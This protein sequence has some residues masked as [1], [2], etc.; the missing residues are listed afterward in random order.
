MPPSLSDCSELILATTNPH[1]VRELATLLLPL[2]ILVRSLDDAEE[3]SPVNEDGTTIAENARKKAIGY[4]RQLGQ[5]VLADDTGLEV[6][7][8][9]GA[10]GVRSARYAGDDATQA[11][12]LAL[13]VEHLKQVPDENRTARFVCHL[14]LADP[15]GKVVLETNGECRGT[16]R[17]E[18]IG[19]YGFGYDSLFEVAGVGKTLAEL[20]PEATA[21]VGHRGKAAREL[22]YAWNSV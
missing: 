10:P 4:A 14:C 21:Q 15:T 8:L 5:W 2:K 7:A 1:K 3:V 13:L 9:N 20:N 17:R 11:M 12:N 6:D 16:I 18:P 19:E 22:I